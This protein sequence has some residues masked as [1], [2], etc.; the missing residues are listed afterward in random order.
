[1]LVDAP[2]HLE[3][4]A[5]VAF[6]QH[7]ARAGNR[8]LGRLDGGGAG[9]VGE[10]DKRDVDLRNGAAVVGLAEAVQDD[11]VEDVGADGDVAALA[12]RKGS[13]RVPLEALGSEG[14]EEARVVGVRRAAAAAAAA[15][16]TR[17][18]LRARICEGGGVYAAPDEH[19][20]HAGPIPAR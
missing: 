2:V 9:P 14:G 19:G 15:R 7:A 20:H 12:G 13:D 1:M 8:G 17:G 3:T 18:A 10:R 11:A 5:V 6:L 4:G 16:A